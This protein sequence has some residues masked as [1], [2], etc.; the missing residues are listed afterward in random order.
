MSN[1]VEAPPYITKAATSKEV[2]RQILAAIHER[3]GPASA[4]PMCGHQEWH[5]LGGLAV[6][7]HQDDYGPVDSFPPS[8]YLPSAVLACMHCANTQLFNLHALGLGHLA[9]DMT[10]HE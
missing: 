4:C 7:L 9:A 6:I 3:I 5:L 2:R 8:A 10:E 1:T